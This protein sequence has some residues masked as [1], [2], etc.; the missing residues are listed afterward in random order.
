MAHTYISQLVHVVFST[1][2]RRDL[3]PENNLDEVWRYL[4]GIARKNGF[5]AIAIGGTQ[6]HAHAL[7]SLP[8]TVPLSKAVQLMKGGSSKWIHEKFGREFA[9]QEAYGAFTIGVSQIEATVAYINAQ[10]AHHQK[11]SFEA[12]FVSFLKKH[13]IEYDK[14]Y[15][16]G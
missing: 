11:A 12:E 2:S 6:N 13:G 1:K 15:V 16:L 14:R 10:I 5:K 3:I 7:L 9:W 4:A 8:E